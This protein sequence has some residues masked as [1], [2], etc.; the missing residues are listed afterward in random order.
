MDVNAMFLP[1]ITILSVG[2]HLMSTDEYKKA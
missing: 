1:R 2:V